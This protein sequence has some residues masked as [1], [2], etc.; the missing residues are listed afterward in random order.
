[1]VK[2]Y[3]LCPGSITGVLIEEEGEYMRFDDLA[4]L[5][6]SHARLLEATKRLVGSLGVMIGDPDNDYDIMYGR[7]AIAAAQ[8]FTET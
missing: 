1:M 6:A 7:V 5:L 4:A 3:G 2:R 8:P